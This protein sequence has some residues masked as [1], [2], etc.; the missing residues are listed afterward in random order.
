MTMGKLFRTLTAATLLLSAACTTSQ[1]TTPPLSGPS[2]FAQSLRVTATP[3]SISK[4]GAS[5]SAIAVNAFDV[6]GRGIPGL[7]LRI[8]MAVSGSVVD[9]GTLSARTI[10]TN[11]NGQA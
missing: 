4:D 1:Q 6:N 10:V 9:Y 8:D 11:S 2:E 3:D 5:Q 7:A